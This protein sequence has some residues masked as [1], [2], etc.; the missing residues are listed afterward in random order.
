MTTLPTKV[1]KE[2]SICTSPTLV[3]T[4]SSRTDVHLSRNNRRTCPHL[5]VMR[6]HV[7]VGSR[8][9]YAISSILIGGGHY[10]ELRR[11]IPRCFF[12]N[13]TYS[14]CIVNGCRGINRV[15]AYLINGKC[16]RQR[17]RIPA[18]LT[19]Y[20]VSVQL[21]LAVALPLELSGWILVGNCRDKLNTQQCPYF[22]GYM[23]GLLAP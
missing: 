15:C 17:R 13:S 8:V 11:T 20:S 19:A 7:M 9:A 22:S 5:L 1:Y 18:L 21:I 4:A 3:L 23:E 6:G 12:L 14:F 10:I 16:R 2:R